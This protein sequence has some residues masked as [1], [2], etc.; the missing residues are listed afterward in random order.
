MRNLRGTL[1]PGYWNVSQ[2]SPAMMIL[3]PNIDAREGDGAFS[4]FGLVSR[5]EDTA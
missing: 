2:R 5:V 3:E 1:W 4:V